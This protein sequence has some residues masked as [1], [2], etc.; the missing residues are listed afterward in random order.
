MPFT[1]IDYDKNG[2]DTEIDL[3]PIKTHRIKMICFL[4]I[5]L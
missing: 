3:D 4:S 2:T 5:V 1:F